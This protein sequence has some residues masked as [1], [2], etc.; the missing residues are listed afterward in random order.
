[1]H[2]ISMKRLREFWEKHP[3]AESPLRHWYKTT[4]RARWYSLAEVRATFPH[5]DPVKVAGGATMIVFNAGGNNYRVVVRL[6]YEFGRVYVKNVMT[7]AEYS[8]DRWKELL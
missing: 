2:V 8:R 1:M 5:A 4:E 6:L 7:H 3:D